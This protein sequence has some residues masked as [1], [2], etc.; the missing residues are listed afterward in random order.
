MLI[1]FI[2]IYLLDGLLSL[3]I[4]LLLKCWKIFVHLSMQVYSLRAELSSRFGWS[5]GQYH[6]G[7]RIL[8][9]VIWDF[10]LAAVKTLTILSPSIFFFVVLFVQYPLKYFCT[11]L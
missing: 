11:E 6:F 8:K 3:G 10:I 7:G 4:I 5:L 2:Y 1:C 9:N